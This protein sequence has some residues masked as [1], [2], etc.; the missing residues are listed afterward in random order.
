MF[1][2]VRDV[3]LKSIYKAV[4]VQV[5]VFGVLYHDEVGCVCQH[6]WVSDSE[7]KFKKIMCANVSGVQYTLMGSQVQRPQSVSAAVET[8]HHPQF[9]SPALPLSPLH[10][11]QFP[12]D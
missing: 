11:S 5:C 10:R 3:L 8:F 4:C 6:P 12:A 7:D 9:P 2:G 1:V